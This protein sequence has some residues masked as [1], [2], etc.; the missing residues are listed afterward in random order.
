VHCITWSQHVITQ[1]LAE[2]YDDDQMKAQ[3]AAK[4]AAGG[5]CVV[6]ELW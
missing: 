5:M 3:I 6:L 4:K 1:A 2:V